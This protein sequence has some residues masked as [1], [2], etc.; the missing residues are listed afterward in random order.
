VLYEAIDGEPT[1]LGALPPEEQALLA[2]EARAALEDAGL[3]LGPDT[4]VVRTDSGP[5]VLVIT[6]AAPP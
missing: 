3:T 1:T 5:V 6:A 2:D 4:R